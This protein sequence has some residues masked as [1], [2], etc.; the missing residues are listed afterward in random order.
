MALPIYE[1]LIVKWS[2]LKRTIPELSH[3]IDVALN[4]LHQYVR[5]A[6]KTRIYALSMSRLSHLD[7]ISSLADESLFAIEVLNPDMKF[8]WMS[9]HWDAQDVANAREWTI[10]AVR[11]SNIHRESNETNQVIY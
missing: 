2:D 9:L 1:V 8:S 10:E 6:R 4:K 7:L 5:E 3:Y 11:L